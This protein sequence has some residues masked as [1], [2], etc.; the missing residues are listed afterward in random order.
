MGLMD[1]VKQGTKEMMIARPDHLKG[2]IIYKHPD[3]TIPFWS[4]LTVDADEG[5]VFFKDGKPGY[6]FDIAA[7]DITAKDGNV[8]RRLSYL[9][10]KPA[11][12]KGKKKKK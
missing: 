3:Q 6:E 7:D 1:F 9:A 10:G 4:Q 11:I 12:I 5:V 2:E 8:R